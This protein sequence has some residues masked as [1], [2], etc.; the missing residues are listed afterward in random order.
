MHMTLDRDNGA[1]LGGLDWAGRCVGRRN[2]VKC[3][4]SLVSITTHAY[5]TRS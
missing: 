4:Y 1:R 5:D 2:G 3:L